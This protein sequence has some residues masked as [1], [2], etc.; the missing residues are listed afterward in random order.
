MR[1]T[2]F[3]RDK[4]NIYSINETNFLTIN[5]DSARRIVNNLP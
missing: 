3:I 2:E 5:T 4:S 1:K